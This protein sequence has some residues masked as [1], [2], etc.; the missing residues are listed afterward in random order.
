MDLDNIAFSYSSSSLSTIDLWLID[1]QD[2][3]LSVALTIA[4]KQLELCTYKCLVAFD[5]DLTERE[6][7]AEA[8]KEQAQKEQAS[9]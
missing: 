9:S 4:W 5:T 1:N 3:S 7:S 8:L 6:H 2:L